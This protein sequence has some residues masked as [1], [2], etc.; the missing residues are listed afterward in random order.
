[1]DQKSRTAI[2]RRRS[3]Q[4][5]GASLLAPLTRP[6]RAAT[7]PPAP[8][9]K[10]GPGEAI[11]TLAAAAGQAR[12]GMRI[13]VAAGDYIGDVASWAQNDLSLKAV[14]G[15]VRLIA[16]G[17]SAQGKGIFVTRGERMRI[18]GFDFSGAVV[19]D[20]NG[21]GIRLEKGS[22]HLLDCTF[23]D[24]E[25]GILTGNDKLSRLEIDDC[26]FGTIVRHE[27][28]NHNLY[29]GSI[30]YLRVSGSHFHHGQLGHLLKSRAAVNHIFYN[31]LADGLGGEASYELDF[32]NGG[33]ALVVGNVIQQSSGTQNP[34][35]ITFGEEGYTWPGQELQL[36]NNTLVDLRPS[37]GVYLRV[38]AGPTQVRIINNLLAGN[39]RFATDGY[40]EV[41]NNFLVDLNVMVLPSRGDFSLRPDAALRGQAI[42]P[43]RSGAI[44]L[45]PSRQFQSP[46]GT[47]ALASPARHPGALQFP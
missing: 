19:S 30:G 4:W 31:R 1:M 47:V 21:A 26:D 43:G 39:P 45:L 25:N 11:K 37:G 13:E 42:D 2:D 15:R 27:G 18:E 32:P 17:Q 7:P 41:R 44:G 5:A 22:L 8:V 10:V 40:W 9:M 34:H 20:Q 23:K 24:N 35:M 38:A 33:Q 36:I 46:R 29:V 6:G 14:G 16:A 28:L 12:D 3:L